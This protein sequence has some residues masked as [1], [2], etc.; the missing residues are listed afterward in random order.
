MKPATPDT[1]VTD[2]ERCLAFVNTLSARPT[3]AP[4]ER[5][6]SYAALAGWA[7]DAGLIGPAEH[8]RLV[9]RAADHGRE[10]SRVLGYA[11]S[12]R[13]AL[14]AVVAARA[15][16]RAAPAAELAT[17][18]GFIAASLDASDLVLEGEAYWWAPRGSDDQLLRPVH[19]LAR[20][21]ARMVS[22][23]LLGRIKACDA[24]DCGWW[25]L[26]DTKNGRR[27]WCDM[28]ICGNRE[29]VRRFR[30]RSQKAD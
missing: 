22:S 2:V 7:R 6:V 24:A 9:A 17:V 20:A 29:K 25:F 11:I 4:V 21:A 16:G 28:K 14:H 10:A 23:P 19:A 5:L 1:A 30:S 27:R 18:A 12:L 15:A 13:E 8:G 26:D 3:E